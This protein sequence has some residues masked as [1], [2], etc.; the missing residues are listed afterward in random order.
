M[1][2]IWIKK[3]ILPIPREIMF[4]LLKTRFLLIMIKLRLGPL[5]NLDLSMRFEV[6]EANTFVSWL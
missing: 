2:A 1:R 5:T 4:F 3:L 6:A